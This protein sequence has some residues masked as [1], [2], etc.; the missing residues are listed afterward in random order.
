M[1]INMSWYKKA[2]QVPTIENITWAIDKLISENYEFSV[3]EL[4]QASLRI[5]G[6]EYALPK[7]AQTA[8][9]KRPKIRGIPQKIED[10]RKTEYSKIFKLFERGMSTLEISRQ[11][12]IPSTLIAKILKIQFKNKTDR[13][14]Y[15]KRK[16]EKNILKTTDELSQEMKEDINIE[17]IGIEDIAYVLDIDSKFIQKVLRDNNINLLKLVTERKNQISEMIA[18]IV[19]DLPYGFTTNDVVAEFKSRH[20]FK[21]SKSNAFRALK[22]NNLGQKNQ[23]SD[24]TIYQALT[25]YISGKMKGGRA[26]LIKDPQRLSLY[27]D[28]FFQD[29]GEKHGFIPPYTQET[30]KRMFLT[31]IQMRENTFNMEKGKYTPVNYDENNPVSFLSNSEEQNE[32]V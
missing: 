16:H 24:D 7:A 30:L 21:L 12:N 1:V 29:Y 19:K 20:N 8:T 14:K 9:K 18:T 32:L 13:D 17:V 31:K 10:I 6:Q 23:E 26:T 2:K 11:L 28:K 22:L 4:Y 5:S 25:T 15:L 27:I 3:E